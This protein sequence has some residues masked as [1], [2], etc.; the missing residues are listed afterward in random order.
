MFDAWWMLAFVLPL[1]FTVVWALLWSTTRRV[2]LWFVAVAPSVSALV[3]LTGLAVLPRSTCRP[4]APGCSLQ[5]RIDDSIGFIILGL[6][7]GFGFLWGTALGILTIMIELW[8]A[9][10][11]GTASGPSLP[12]DP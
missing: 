11:R 4:H 5:E 9:H 6:N 1:L 2:R 12:A 8:R 3:F 7:C 10:R